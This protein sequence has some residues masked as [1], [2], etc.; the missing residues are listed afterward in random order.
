MP[1]TRLFTRLILAAACGIVLVMMAAPVAVAD[2]RSGFLSDYSQLKKEKDP[3]G[4]SREVW[5]SPK[6]TKANYQK[7]LLEP[8]T[9]H[10]KPEPTSTVPDKTLTDVLAYIDEVVRKAADAEIPIVDKPGPGV[11]RVRGALTAVDLKKHLK[12]WEYIPIGMVAAGV[13]EAAGV[14]KHDVHIFVEWEMTDSVTNEPLARAVRETKGIK[15]D[16]KDVLTL[17]E[18]KPVLDE[19]GEGIRRMIEIRLKGVAP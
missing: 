9:F 7:V 16:R 13:K 10:P 8:M 2:E 5:I 6:L 12:P 1:E 11:T 4:R 17:E 3:L 18:A 15:L 14:R 19:W